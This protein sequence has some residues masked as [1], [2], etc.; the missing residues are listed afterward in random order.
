MLIN[1]IDIFK[2]SC[3]CFTD[4]FYSFNLT[5][6]S[7]LSLFFCLFWA[8]FALLFKTF[9][10]SGNS[11]NPCCIN[12]WMN[13]G[14][15]SPSFFSWCTLQYH[16]QSPWAELTELRAAL[17]NIRGLELGPG[18]ML[19]ENLGSDSSVCRSFIWAQLPG[20]Y[21]VKRRRKKWALRLSSNWATE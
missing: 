17:T 2:Y 12:I 5:N 19:R 3:F 20:A 18:E 1:F 8:Y 14:M 11:T 4:L 9:S 7:S 15:S 13:T 6:I 21:I 10:E 16:Q